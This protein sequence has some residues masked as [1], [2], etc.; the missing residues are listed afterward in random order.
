[1]MQLAQPWALLALAS[2]PILLILHSLR[3]RRRRL[4]VSSNALWREALRE[5]QRGLGLQ[6]LLRDASLL[7]LL[8]LAA[9]LSLALAGPRWTSLTGEGDDTVVVLDASASMRARVAGGGTRFEAARREAA[10]LIG[11]MP[12]GGRMLIMTSARRPVLR[13]AFEHDPA[14]LR[15]RLDA[16]EPTDEAGRPRA[17]LELALSLLRNR[18][19][20]RVYFFTD[21]A[22]DEDVDL[23]SPRIEYRRVGAAADNVA[24]TRFDLRSEPGSADRFEVLLTVRNFTAEALDVPAVVSVEDVELLRR[25][26]HVPA[27]GHE[28]V[29]AAFRGH[30]AG[31]ARADIDVDDALDVDDHAFA[32]VG[33]EGALHVLLVTRGNFFLESVLAAMPNVYFTRM[34]EVWSERFARQAARHD[35][36]V[37]DRVEAP[38]LPPGNYLLLDTLPPG[39]PFTDAGRVSRPVISGRGSSA[40]MRRVDLAAVQIDAARRV[41]VDG[42]PPGLQRLFWSPETD[43]ALALLR[44]DVRLVYLGFDLS[45]SNFP[46][47]AAFPLFIRQSVEWLRPRGERASAT[48]V[49]AGEAHAI[50]VPTRGSEVM[51]QVPSGAR[52]RFRVDAASLVFEDTAQAGFYRY[53]IG[54]DRSFFAVN[55]G[56]ARESDIRP[57]AVFPAARAA[58]ESAGPRSRASVALWPWL[59]W[60]ALAIAA[61]EWLVW[62]A[63][64]GSA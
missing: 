19:R 24:I 36:V 55:P 61:A 1:M 5:R 56:D 22:F 54:N 26:V 23:G 47:Q 30:A 17:A 49:T 35:L 52:R 6:K 48:Q 18:D 9:V 39:L 10:D 62:C 8:L 11:R 50:A 38:A 32:V 59:A 27:G 42:E 43:L 16:L 58:P 64:R 57:R 7:L 2:V 15:R 34:D 25:T 28:T 20:A 40:L 46:L 60:A 37:L 63:R 12:R 4:E 13:S 29:V 51:V 41:V 21:A 45:R 53:T 14:T 31:R 44:D 33:E 3:P